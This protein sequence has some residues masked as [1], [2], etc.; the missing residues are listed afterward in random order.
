M[1]PRPAIYISV[2]LDR[3][4]SFEL[5][6]FRVAPDDCPHMVLHGRTDSIF[7]GDYHGFRL[8]FHYDECRVVLED[9]IED[10]LIAR[11]V[12]P[13]I[14][15]RIDEDAEE[16]LVIAQNPE[17]TPSVMTTNL[18]DEVSVQSSGEQ[19]KR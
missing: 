5:E 3:D 18:V 16:E 6:S 2:T 4:S 9:N 11:G 10:V 1:E 14:H 19:T 8:V 7:L 12:L 17:A 15:L 13:V